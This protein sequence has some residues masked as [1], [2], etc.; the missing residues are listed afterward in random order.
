MNFNQFQMFLRSK[1][2]DGPMAVVLTQ[3]YERI[4]D[5]AKQTDQNAKIC[6]QLAESM[7]SVVSL[8]EHLRAG[9]SDTRARLGIDDSVRSEPM[10]DDEDHGPN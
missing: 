10:T 9:I 4:L 8:H 7:E 5:I 2:I 3:M 6:L 1:D